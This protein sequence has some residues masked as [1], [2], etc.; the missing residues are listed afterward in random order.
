MTEQI[1]Y[2]HTWLGSFLSARGRS[3]GL[4][5]QRSSL[6]LA[7]AQSTREALLWLPWCSGLKQEIKFISCFSPEH[8]GSQSKA[9][10]WAAEK[11]G[12]EGTPLG[13]RE[14]APRPSGDSLE[15]NRLFSRI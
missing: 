9:Q 10:L 8:Q 11:Q 14:S 13:R 5:T 1:T 4:A 3:E 12:L 6:S 15:Q 2:T 7:L